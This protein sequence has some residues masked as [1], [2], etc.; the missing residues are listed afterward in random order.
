MLARTFPGRVVSDE[1]VAAGTHWYRKISEA[2]C[3]VLSISKAASL[4]TR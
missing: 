1:I 4:P 2:R 3:F